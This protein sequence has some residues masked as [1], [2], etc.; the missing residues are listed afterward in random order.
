MNIKKND[1]VMVIAGKDKGKSGRVYRVMPSDEKVL[2]E[3]LNVIKRH[4]RPSA[5][6]RQG[7][8]IE[9]EAPLQVSN[10]MVICG[11]CNKPT[12]VAHSFE[13]DKK[14]RVCKKCGSPMD[15]V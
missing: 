4:T 7:G 5:T 11:K 15:K 2:V 14:V 10:V 9:K 3:K 13:G 6:N 12:R 8:I 1:M